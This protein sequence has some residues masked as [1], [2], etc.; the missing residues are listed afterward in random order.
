M[1][2]LTRTMAAALI[3]AVPYTVLAQEY[4][5]APPIA[6]S[7]MLNYCVYGGL[8]YSVGSQ[9][10]IMKGSPPLYCDQPAVPQGATAPRPRAMWTTSQPPATINCTN[11]LITGGPAR[12]LR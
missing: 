8:V 3:V 6:P 1:G 4:S 5:S 11:D 7:D 12:P 10:C 9:I 2:L